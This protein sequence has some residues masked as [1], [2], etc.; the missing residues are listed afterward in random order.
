MPKQIIPEEIMI[1]LLDG[2]TDGI[3]KIKLEGWDVLAYKIP[4]D[5]LNNFNELDE[6]PGLY[7]LLSPPVTSSNGKPCVYVGIAEQNS[8]KK[9]INEGHAFNANDW[10]WTE[11]IIFI[12]ETPKTSIPQIRYLEHKFYNLIKDTQKYFLIN[13][14]EPKRAFTKEYLKFIENAKMIM[15]ILG[16]YMFPHLSSE[17]ISTSN[18]NSTSSKKKNIYHL[19]SSNFKAEGYPNPTSSNKKQFSVLKGSICRSEVCKSCPQ[20]II[21]KREE[22]IKSNKIKNW[23]FTVD[24]NFPTSSFAAGCIKGRHTSGP[25]SWLDSNGNP[26]KE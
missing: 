2:S 22:L 23:I 3:W 7:F 19:S 18:K 1:H 6:N 12:K 9:R 8:V 4:K 26:L 17:N 10:N 16:H 20:H 25:K 14:N 5:E 15:T 13:R 24:V 11:A 21:S